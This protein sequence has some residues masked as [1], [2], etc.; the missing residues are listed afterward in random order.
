[1][2]LAYFDC[3]SGISGDMTLGALI[4]LGVPVDWLRQQLAEMPL[5]GFDLSVSEVSRN[6]IHAR[7]VQVEVLDHEH[8]RNYMDIR[9]LILGSSLSA[10][11]QATS[12]KIFDRIAETEARIHK[13]P[14]ERVHFHEVGGIDAIVDIVGTALCVEYLHIEKILASRIPLGSGFVDC[15]H[16][17][18]P[19]PAP[20]TLEIL[21]GVPVYGTGLAQE[22]VTPTG[23]AIIVTLAQSF[24]KIPDIIV[25]KTGY[26]AGKHV[27]ESVPNLL[28][29]IIGTRSEPHKDLNKGVL[30]DEIVIVE[31]CIDDMNPEVF[32][33]LMERLFEDGALDVYWI[34]VYMKKNR[35]GTMVQVLCRENLKETIVHR[36]LTETTSAG[37]RFYD[38][39]RRI[40][41]RE[42]VEVNSTYGKIQVKRMVDPD[43]GVRMVPEFESCKKIA[44]EKNVPIRIVYDE[45]IR[46]LK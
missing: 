18:L 46:S 21:K 3:F 31:T 34:P 22:L 19:V 43:G 8:S 2:M 24:G 25:E 26:G 20:A 17:T 28:R 38:A 42:Q 14:K 6:N 30:S 4:D 15:R 36:L 12:L 32:G 16:G 13:C 37:V 29:I 33:F 23:A 35:P 1:M 5:T 40:L 41:A 10:E 27:F 39:H 11:V 7:R 44:R 45:I 9:S